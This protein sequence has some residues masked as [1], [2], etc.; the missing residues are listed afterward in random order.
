MN[1]DKILNS[2]Y[3]KGEGGKLAYKTI[4][5]RIDEH[6][7]FDDNNTIVKFVI[8]DRLD[9]PHFVEMS[10]NSTVIAALKALKSQNT[11]FSI[12][13]IGARDGYCL[14]NHVRKIDKAPR[15]RWMNN[16]RKLKNV[17]WH[18]LEDHKEESKYSE[19]NK[20]FEIL[21]DITQNM[22]VKV[23]SK[24]KQL[25][26]EV[27]KLGKIGISPNL[28]AMVLNKHPDTIMNWKIAAVKSKEYEPDKISLKDEE[29]IYD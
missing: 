13:L 25:G 14:L 6:I 26:F 16:R 3:A 11:I 5:S 28:L 21:Y 29:G 12:L 24:R 27:L 4:V 22:N 9:K 1:N 20:F 2:R 10:A 19:F 8:G 15:Y 17:L 23:I 7:Q 18:W